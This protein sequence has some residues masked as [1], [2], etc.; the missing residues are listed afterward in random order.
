MSQVGV[1]LNDSPIHQLTER[2]ELE[3]CQAIL[4]LAAKSLPEASLLL[5]I[6]VHVIPSVL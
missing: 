4:E 1:L 3:H 6:R 2:V 5:L